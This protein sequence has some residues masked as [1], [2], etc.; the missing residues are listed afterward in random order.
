MGA[1]QRELWIAEHP[2]TR[3]ISFAMMQASGSSHPSSQA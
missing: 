3:P 1:Y 2:L